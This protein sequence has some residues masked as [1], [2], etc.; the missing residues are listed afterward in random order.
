MQIQMTHVQNRMN[1]SSLFVHNQ[2]ARALDNEEQE[3]SLYSLKYAGKLQQR[4]VFAVNSAMRVEATVSSAKMAVTCLQMVLRQHRAL[5]S[6]VE[7]TYRLKRC[8]SK[9]RL[10]ALCNQRTQIKFLEATVRKKILQIVALAGQQKSLE[11][12][13]RL[14]QF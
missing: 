14:R 8:L 5:L 1:R 3:Q 2:L 12:A 6:K 10:D 11:L 7:R 13:L 4:H 9:L